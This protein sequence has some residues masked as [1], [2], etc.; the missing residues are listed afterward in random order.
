MRAFWAGLLWLCTLM[1]VASARPDISAD[2]LGALPDIEELL[3]KAGW[4]MTPEMS[5]GFSRPGDIMDG[6]H[7]MV[8]SGPSCFSAKEEQGAFATM[9]VT[10]SMSAGVR[11]RAT[12]SARAGIALDKKI[13]FDT[14]IYRR[15]P[16]LQLRPAPSCIEGLK[17]AYSQGE[18]LSRFYV[19]TE[20]L[21]AKIQQQQCGTYDAKAGM[22]VVSADASVAQECARTS[23]EPVAVA[24]KIQPVLDLPGVRDVIVVGG[25]GSGDA[26]DDFGAPPSAVQQM[27]KEQACEDAAKTTGQKART[28]ELSRRVS[29]FMARAHKAWVGRSSELEACTKLPRSKRDGCITSATQWLKTARNKTVQL[30]AGAER[31]Q[32]DCGY[33]TQAFPAMSR[34]I[35]AADVA[36]AEAL[37]VRLQA[38]DAVAPSP[39]ASSDEVVGRVGPRPV[40]LES[41]S[42]E[43]RETLKKEWEGCR[44][45]SARQ[46]S[47]LGLMYAKGGITQSYSRAW[48]LFWQGCYGGKD[49]ACN[50]LGL[51]YLNGRGVTRSDSRAVQ[52]YKQGCDGGSATGCSNLGFMYEK[53][54][55]V[56]Q[57]DSRAVQL[58]RQG[59]DGGS[60]GGCSYLGVMY[61]KGRGVTQSVSRAVQLYKQACEGGSAFGCGNLGWMY[62]HGRGVTQSDSRARQLYKQA[63]DGGNHWSCNRLKQMNN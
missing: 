61:R 55:G 48:Q 5:A 30:P 7:S 31:V 6:Q 56:T 58:L 52:L 10:R 11:M 33:K 49:W 20:S 39:S 24:Y 43:E 37:L 23:L 32:T 47:N 15:I 18:D 22:F 51:I 1:P 46:C 36:S 54:R 38:D 42:S 9:E 25:S 40:P 44:D 45:G 60:M 59:C 63:C 12:I 34:S 62:A 26:D 13:I 3:E 17:S 2:A 50:N 8:L 35:A 19:I 14:P 4:T 16:R 29:D 57:S 27:L 53:G 21:S 41:A 28:S